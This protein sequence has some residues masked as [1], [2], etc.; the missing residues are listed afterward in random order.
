[1]DVLI[2]QEW[3]ILTIQLL[4]Q[5]TYYQALTRDNAITKENKECGN[6][7]EMNTRAKNR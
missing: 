2:F 4:Y 5:Y 6:K 1:M 3:N 7:Y